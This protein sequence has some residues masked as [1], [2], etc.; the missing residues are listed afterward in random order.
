LPITQLNDIELITISFVALPEVILPE[1]GVDGSLNLALED[2]AHVA[3]F[4]GTEAPMR[5]V[6]LAGGYASG[7]VGH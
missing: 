6:R 3:R 7:Y 4:D 2:V 1:G 5:G